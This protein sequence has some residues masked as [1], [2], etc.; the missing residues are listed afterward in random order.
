MIIFISAK[1]KK[2]SD[3]FTFTFKLLNPSSSKIL[4]F[5]IALSTKASG[6]GSLNFSKISFSNDPAFTPTLIEQ[7]FS[8]AD[9]TTS[10]ILFLSPMLPG[11]ILRQLAPLSAASIALL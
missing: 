8:L 9:L 4:I 1:D 6:Q 2:T 3:D 7:L 10:L 5:L 11:L